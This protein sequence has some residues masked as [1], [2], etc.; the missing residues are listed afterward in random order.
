MTNNRRATECN[1]CECFAHAWSKT[2]RWGVVIVDA[3]D[4]YFL[5][6]YT[7]NLKR[8]GRVFYA[9]SNT[10]ARNNYTSAKL[11]RAI[12]QSSDDLDHKNSNG[13]DCRRNNLREA[14]GQNSRNS[15]IFLSTKTSRFK[16]VD[17]FKGK[18]RARILVRDK[19]LGL[20]NFDREENA[21]LAY[22]FAALEHFGEFAR[23]NV[24]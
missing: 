14:H 13:L 6:D 1:F 15:R 23:Y 9:H 20:G 5:I 17:R 4:A 10:F 12:I 16:G 3:A 24:A 2:N 21:A 7:W 18:W 8:D 22:N 11:H 19:R